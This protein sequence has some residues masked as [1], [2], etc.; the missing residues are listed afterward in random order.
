MSR[1]LNG[2]GLA[3]SVALLALGLWGRLAPP[4]DRGRFA[5]NLVAYDDALAR[6][7]AAHAAL[8]ATPA[9]VAAATEIYDS[10]TAYAWPEGLARVALHD[11]WI[12]AALSLAD[13]LLRATGLKPDGALFGQ[14]ESFRYERALGRGFGI[15]SQNALGLAD[16]L[17][18]RY[19]IPA[20]MAGLGGHVVIQV[21][22]PA[23]PMIADPSLGVTMPFG[24]DHAQSHVPEV[25]AIYARRTDDRIWRHY[26]PAGN[27]LAP[28]TGSG[29]YAVPF[30]KLNLVEDAESAADYAAVG[31]PA[32]GV[33]F[34]AWAL[35]RR[36]DPAGGRAAAPPRGEG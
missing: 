30:W 20:R 9:F 28:E 4:D 19:G 12:L 1:A 3:I 18:R 32:A 13:P 29:A 11:N 2:V 35:R 22:L 34:F 25:G 7:D 14:F 23:G 26:D 24:L 21:E 16:L 8:G 33:L 5:E 10:A 17:D 27:V 6:M 31:L 15:C 36:R